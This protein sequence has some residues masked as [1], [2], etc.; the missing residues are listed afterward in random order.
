MIDYHYVKHCDVPARLGIDAEQWR[1]HL[2]CST[3]PPNGFIEL[4]SVPTFVQNAELPAGEPSDWPWT[5]R[6]HERRHYAPDHSSEHVAEAVREGWTREWDDDPERYR[7]FELTGWCRV[8]LSTVKAVARVANQAVEAELFP[9]PVRASFSLASID[10]PPGTGPYITANDV[11]FRR[12]DIDA[13]KT[14]TGTADT[15]KAGL[16]DPRERASLYRIIGALAAS[17]NLSLTEHFKAAL[18]LQAI[19]ELA[20]IQMADATIAKHLKAADTLL[21]AESTQWP[22]SQ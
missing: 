5:V 3:D 21:R 14:A 16:L 15:E 19:L 13:L 2:L 17:A 18:P 1:Q 22:P 7:E 4:H 8:G 11:W 6:W 10:V 12:E 9:L 20:G